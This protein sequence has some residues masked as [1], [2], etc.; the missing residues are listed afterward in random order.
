M[1]DNVGF[2]IEDF[3]ALQYIRDSLGKP[4]MSGVCE[5]L[6]MVADPDDP[7]DLYGMVQRSGSMSQVA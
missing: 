3:S 5:N 2:T 1:F 7:R 6:D 4:G